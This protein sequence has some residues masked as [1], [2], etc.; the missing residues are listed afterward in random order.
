VSENSR[1]FRREVC[2]QHDYWDD[3]ADPECPWCLLEV[4][5]R[6][7]DEARGVVACLHAEQNGPPLIHH[8]AAWNAAMARAEAVLSAARAAAKEE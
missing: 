1:T 4:A 3:D 2:H 6:E 7:R 8:E 5:E